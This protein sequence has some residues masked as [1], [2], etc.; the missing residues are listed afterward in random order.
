VYEVGIDRF[1]AMS[2]GLC[3]ITVDVSPGLQAVE[4]EQLYLNADIAKAFDLR[5]DERAVVRVHSRWVHIRNGEHAHRTNTPGRPIP[6]A[7]AGSCF[8]PSPPW[9]TPYPSDPST[10]AR[11]AARALDEAGRRPMMRSSTSADGGSGW[12][13]Q[14]NRGTPEERI[15]DVPGQGRRP[16]PALY[17]RREERS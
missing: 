10:G 6:L 5:S 14:M 16:M 13:Y 7:A 2:N 12:S 3:E 17:V 15:A 11:R 1:E 4:E 8:Q 9:R